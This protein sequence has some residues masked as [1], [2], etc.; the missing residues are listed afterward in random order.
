MFFNMAGIV[1]LIL[2]I[3]IFIFFL[4]I[5]PG[6]GWTKSIDLNKN[7][8]LIFISIAV[9]VTGVVLIVTGQYM[10]ELHEQAINER[11]RCQQMIAGNAEGLL[12]KELYS[13]RDQENRPPLRTYLFQEKRNRGNY[14]IIATFNSTSTGQRV[15]SIRISSGSVP[16]QISINTEDSVCPGVFEENIS[17]GFDG[18]NKQ[19]EQVQFDLLALISDK[20]STETDKDGQIKNVK[21]S[22]R[23]KPHREHESNMKANQRAKNIVLK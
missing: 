5:D 19:N 11:N 13:L 7:Y 21:F 14:K 18:H 17:I 23:N 20:T 12:K 2:G 10:N 9:C 1:F 8:I 22:L 16:Q 15:R 6:Y 3:V 4:S